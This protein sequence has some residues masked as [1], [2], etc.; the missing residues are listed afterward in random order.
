M[1]T[2]IIA[3]ELGFT[4][5]DIHKPLLVPMHVLISCVE[6]HLHSGKYPDICR[7]LHMA[8]F[9]GGD[10]QTTTVHEARHIPYRHATTMD[11]SA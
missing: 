1:M 8:V 7:R 3:N 6:K 2:G 9:F 5:Q 4:S 10:E 11:E